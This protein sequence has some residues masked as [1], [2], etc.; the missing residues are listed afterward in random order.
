LLL[1]AGGAGTVLLF[2]LGLHLNLLAAFAATG[3]TA[4]ALHG[5]GDLIERRR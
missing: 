3:C 2:A 1:I 5:A 4:M